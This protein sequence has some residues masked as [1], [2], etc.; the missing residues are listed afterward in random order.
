MPDDQNPTTPSTS[1]PPDTPSPADASSGQGPTPPSAPQQPDI[2]QQADQMRANPMANLPPQQQQ[3]QGPNPQQQAAFADIASHSAFG[4]AARFLLGQQVDYKVG[5]NGQIV[6]VPVQQTPGS[7]FRSLV[8]GAILG[9]ATAANTPVSNGV[10]GGFGAGMVRGAAAGLQQ[11]QSEDQQ[12]YQRAQQTFENQLKLREQQRADENQKSE[13]ALRQADIAHANAMTLHENFLLQKDQQ[14]ASVEAGQTGKAMLQPFLD[15][16]SEMK[17]QDIGESQMKQILASNPQAG[18]YLWQQTGVQAKQDA[19]GNMYLEKTYSAIDPKGTVKITQGMLDEWKAVGLDKFA[20]DVKKFKVG[21]EI[22]AD[23]AVKL[24]TQ[25]KQRFVQKKTED[26]ANLDVQEKNASIAEKNAQASHL[27]QETAKSKLDEKDSQLY[28]KALDELDKAGGDF[29]KL[30]P[31]S[32]QV[33][34]KNTTQL[35]TALSNAAKAAYASGDMDQ[36]TDLMKEVSQL[37]RLVPK[38]YGLAGAAP[39]KPPQPGA[40][41]PDNIAKQ[42]LD[43]ANGDPNKAREAAKADGWSVPGAAAPTAEDTTTPDTLAAQAKGK[44]A[45]SIGPGPQ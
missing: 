17:Y 12:R 23:D 44:L 39:P 9:G 6:Q 36:A 38:A 3:P 37:S 32:K 22:S 31:G 8:A 21:Q 10:A 33:I 5:P 25:Y 27:A 11:A 45:R 15:A 2:V 42:Y 1:T 40:A 24:M 43:Q 19:K 41:L 16:G 28:T 29:D 14:S 13:E 20:P 18:G 26:A 34:A 7:M 35:I 30:T 4:K